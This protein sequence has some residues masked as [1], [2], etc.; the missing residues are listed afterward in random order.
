MTM[1]Q[2]R[3]VATDKQQAFIAKLLAEKDLSGT[4]YQG[5]TPDWSRSTPQTATL[6]ITTLLKLPKNVASDPVAGV[7]E[8]GDD[9]VRV[10]LGQKTNRMLATKVVFVDGRVDYE[11]L[12]LAR[13]KVPAGARR[14]SLDEVGALGKSWDHC[15]MCGRRLDVPESV[16][17]GIGPVCA[18]K[19]AD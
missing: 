6:V 10:Y 12:G 4:A 14:L 19:Y 9:L 5:W 18:A 1:T 17:R 11:Y 15:L 7:Y 3:R 16:D 13:N 8:A 2:I